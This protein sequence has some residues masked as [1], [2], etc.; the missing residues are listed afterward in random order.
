M[1]GSRLILCLLTLTLLMI[2]NFC[3]V[4][5]KFTFCAFSFG[6]KPP[7]T[8]RSGSNRTLCSKMLIK[9]APSLKW[10][11]VND[12]INHVKQVQVVIVL[13]TSLLDSLT[14]SRF[15]YR[16]PAYHP[17]AVFAVLGALSLL[18]SPFWPLQA[19]LFWV[20]IRGTNHATCVTVNQSK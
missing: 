9:W 13:Y 1:S 3:D 8:G 16:H 14:K 19:S 7:T 12:E 18:P 6:L 4:I 5:V 20:E 2:L 10:P 15:F 17:W 11:L